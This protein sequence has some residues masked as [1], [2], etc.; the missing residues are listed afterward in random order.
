[1]KPYRDQT[2]LKS[3]V[4]AQTRGEDTYYPTDAEGIPLTERDPDTGEWP[5]NTKVVKK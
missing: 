5:G 2:K 1:V 4:A 3:L